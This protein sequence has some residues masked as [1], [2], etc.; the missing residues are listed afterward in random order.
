[1]TDRLT[2]HATQS[3]TVGRVYICRAEMQ[4]NNN[5]DND[6]DDVRCRM[7]K[8]REETVAHLTSECSKLAQL[9]YK[10]RHDIVGG[11]PRSSLC[12]KYGLPHFELWYQRTAE[13]LL[14]TEKV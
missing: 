6:D 7:C 1:M 4:P 14:E 5:N 11:I 10:K 13:P 2:D 9:E 12:E 3:V 8:D